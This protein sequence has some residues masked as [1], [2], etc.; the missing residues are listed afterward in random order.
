[1]SVF[2]V[3][4]PEAQEALGALLAAHCPRPAVLYLEGD[5]GAGKTTLARGFLRAL[6]HRGAVRSPTYTLLEPY[7]LAA[8]S[9]FHL[10]LYR[11]ADPEELAYLGLRDLVGE[12][13]IL[14]VEW[15]ERGEGGLPPADLRIRIE[16]RGAGRQVDLEPATPEGRLLAAK[17]TSAL[18]S[19]DLPTKQDMSR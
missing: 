7:E 6:G 5:L 18:F 3:T 16:H 9:V 11:L 10:D 14:I 8:G 4:G 1:M 13:A 19:G 2:E 12:R 17:V 15:P